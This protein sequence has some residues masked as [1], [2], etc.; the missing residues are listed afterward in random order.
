[1]KFFSNKRGMS[2]VGNVREATVK[3]S[4]QCGCFSE[5]WTMMTQ[6][7]V[8][9][10]GGNLI[11][12]HYSHPAAMDELGLTERGPGNEK[13]WRMKPR[14]K[15]LIKAQSLIFTTAFI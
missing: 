4:Q 12:P 6:I 1:M 7:D 11:G 15:F 10:K 8:Q 2:P 5:T 14:Q 9:S 3:K 13:G